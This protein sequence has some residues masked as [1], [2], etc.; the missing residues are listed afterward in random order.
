[1]L[2]QLDVIVVPSLWYET[3]CFVIS[4]AFAMGVPVIASDLGVV[5]ER[6]RHGVDGLL[7]APGDV[8]QLAQALQTVHDDPNLINRLRQN[9]PPIGT[10]AEHTAV[11]AQ[12]YY[13]ILGIKQ[14]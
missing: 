4:E 5:G 7:F 13:E 1:M 8:D 12:L 11:I 10:V 6:V 9:I 3:F 14:P 2:A